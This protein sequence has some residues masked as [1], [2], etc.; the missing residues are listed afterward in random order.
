M[1]PSKLRKQAKDRFNHYCRV[2]VECDGKNCRGEI[3]GMGGIGTGRSFIDNYRAL[4]MYQL[5]L[6]SMHQAVQPE[7]ELILFGEKMATPIIPAPVGGMKLNFDN[8]MSEQ[9]Y[10]DS[11][12]YGAKKAGTISSCGD[13]K[14]PEVLESG[15]RSFTNAG[16]HGIAFI[17]PRSVDEIIQRIQWAEHAGALAVGVDVDAC[18]FDVED[19]GNYVGPKSFYQ[20]RR[21]VQSTSLPFIIK[22]IMTVQEAEMAVEMGAAGIV[23]SN[24]GGRVLDYTPGTAEVLPEIAEKVK[25]EIII[26]I[27]GG[28]RSGIDV[29][30]VLA[31]GAEYALI[32]RPV[33]KGAF[34][35][36]S[37]G[38]TSVIDEMT[39]ELKRTMI[40]TGCAHVKAIDERVIY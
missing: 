39:S 17:K 38:V 40:V 37:Q 13:G 35:A 14:A 6:R 31:L 22:G 1:E 28:I 5:N 4:N 16:V 32:G 33:I 2:C 20:M 18:A 27:D 15:L 30:K 36:G 23:I 11:V 26:M 3:P 21:I 12:S 9:D 19:K 8:L 7:T 34:A 10:A 25:G 29:L 24:H